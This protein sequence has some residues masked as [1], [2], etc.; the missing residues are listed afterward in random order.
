MLSLT[1]MWRAAD[2]PQSK[3]P[4]AWVRLPGTCEF[5]EHICAVLRLSQDE[6]IQTLRGNEAGTWAHWQI[7][8]AYA[9]KE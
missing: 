7:A 9:K 5:V 1:D 6:S 2:K 3:E 4:F 8:M